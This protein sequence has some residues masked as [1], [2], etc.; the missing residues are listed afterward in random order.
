MFSWYGN[1]CTKEVHTKFLSL[2]LTKLGYPCC[3]KVPKCLQVLCI[4]LS[5]LLL[6]YTGVG[7]SALL[8]GQLSHYH[9]KEVLILGTD[10]CIQ[11][12]RMT[13]IMVAGMV[14]PCI[15]HL[16]ILLIQS[17][18]VTA[19]NLSSIHRTFFWHITE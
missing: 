2:I 8:A 5:I 16:W 15:S 4:S 1:Y 7:G 19:I 11:L 3:L 17:K 14:L 10:T 12:N 13:S 18:R 9:T 6:F